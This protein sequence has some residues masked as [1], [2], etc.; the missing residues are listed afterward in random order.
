[1]TA[2]MKADMND[3]SDMLLHSWWKKRL[4][5]KGKKKKKVK[6]AV[7]QNKINLPT[8]SDNNAV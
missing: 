7:T 8:S 1:M 5:K 2:L 3:V 4:K 6:S